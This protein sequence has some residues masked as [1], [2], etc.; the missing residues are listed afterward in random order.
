MSQNILS[1]NS[2]DLVY[3]LLQFQLNINV[4][5]SYFRQHFHAI[6]PESSSR[7]HGKLQIAAGSR[8]FVSEIIPRKVKE[9]LETFCGKWKEKEGR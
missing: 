9:N 2:P 1:V 3:V 5:I 7:N 6:L 8:Y 4:L